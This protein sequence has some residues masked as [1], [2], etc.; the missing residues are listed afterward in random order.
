MQHLLRTCYFH[1]GHLWLKV[2]SATGV[3][4]A[5]R[6][7]ATH[8]EWLVLMCLLLSLAFSIWN[9]VKS[10]NSLTGWDFGKDSRFVF[11]ILICYDKKERL[12]LYF[13]TN[14]LWQKDDDFWKCF[15]SSEFL[16]LCF[17]PKQFLS[18]I[19]HWYKVT[20]DV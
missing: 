5:S 15:L 3:T 17:Y 18:K 16:N 1:F 14:D 11:K 12:H 6:G 2:P 8:R 7:K 10:K 20:R 19:E 4:E 9:K 13:M